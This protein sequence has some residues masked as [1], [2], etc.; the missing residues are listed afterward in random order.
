M[1]SF[2]K[3]KYQNKDQAADDLLQEENDYYFKLVT[4][5]SQG[6]FK[7]LDT[8]FSEV[9]SQATRLFTIRFETYM[10]HLEKKPLSPELVSVINEQISFKEFIAK[11]LK[12]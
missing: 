3:E 4:A 1:L 9:D 10:N 12:S 6:D 8:A 7:T 2:L 5:L 11:M